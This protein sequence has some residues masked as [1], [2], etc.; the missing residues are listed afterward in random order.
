[1]IGSIA[2]YSLHLG[3]KQPLPRVEDTRLHIFEPQVA[4]VV[5]YCLLYIRRLRGGQV[6]FT[7]GDGN[8]A[9]IY[10]ALFWAGL[11]HCRLGAGE[12]NGRNVR[13][14]RVQRLAFLGR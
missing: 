12:G 7:A 9:V 8:V 6:F 13:F 5:L 3:V 4:A 1:M 11:A 2:Q 10:C 14:H